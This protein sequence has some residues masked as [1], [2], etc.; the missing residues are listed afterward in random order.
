MNEEGQTLQ[1]EAGMDYEYLYQSLAAASP[2]R[3]PYPGMLQL[4]EL[5]AA[6]LSPEEIQ[7]KYEHMFGTQRDLCIHIALE[8]A[9]LDWL[10]LQ[11]DIMESCHGPV[12]PEGCNE[13]MA[14]GLEVT[15]QI[16][17]LLEEAYRKYLGWDLTATRESP[18]DAVVV[19][20]LDTL[21]QNQVE[22]LAYWHATVVSRQETNEEAEERADIFGKWGWL[23]G[24]LK[25]WGQSMLSSS[26]PRYFR[27]GHRQRDEWEKIIIP[28]ISIYQDAPFHGHPERDAEIQAERTIALN[29]WWEECKRRLPFINAERIDYLRLDI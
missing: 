21:E 8:M 19:Q 14:D 11:E 15:N 23:L 7:Q 24:A 2:Q 9:L 16:L 13:V 17:G 27:W 6:L 12:A 29:E 18:V 28:L 25:L 22:Q 10:D 1:I 26:S 20:I 5:P 3:V 4:P